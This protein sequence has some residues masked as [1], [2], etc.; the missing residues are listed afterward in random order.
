MTKRVWFHVTE[1]IG[2]PV[3]NMNNAQVKN[4]FL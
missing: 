2:M 4:D 3:K 1:L